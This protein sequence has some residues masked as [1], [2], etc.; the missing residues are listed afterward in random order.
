MAKTLVLRSPDFAAVLQIGGYNTSIPSA[1]PPKRRR[2]IFA[3][4]PRAG[5]EVRLH[6]SHAVLLHP[7]AGLPDHFVEAGTVD[8]IPIS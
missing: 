7:Y 3:R 6:P 2:P 8:P 4:L 5:A 1:N